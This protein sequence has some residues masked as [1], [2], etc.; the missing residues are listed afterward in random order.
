MLLMKSVCLKRR[1]QQLHTHSMEFSQQHQQ[2]Q[3][4]I[5]TLIDDSKWQPLVDFCNY[6]K[7]FTPSDFFVGF[8]VNSVYHHEFFWIVENA[9]FLYVH[10]NENLWLG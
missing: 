10:L 7:R 6:T 5:H 4:A 1:A 3:N 2:Q 8:F 9:T